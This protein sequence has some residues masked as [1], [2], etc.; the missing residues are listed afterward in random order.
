MVLEQNANFSLTVAEEQMIQ[1]NR[2]VTHPHQI[3]QIKNEMDEF[4]SEDWGIKLQNTVQKGIASESQSL[5][6][7]GHLPRNTKSWRLTTTPRC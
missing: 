6:V 3:E 1:R 5:K 4:S 7:V 2:T